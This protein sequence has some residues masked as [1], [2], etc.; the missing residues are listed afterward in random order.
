MDQSFSPKNLRRIWDLEARRGR[1]RLDLFPE[2]RRAYETARDAKRH[3]RAV[4]KSGVQFSGPSKHHP[5][6]LARET[7][8]AADELLELSL[9]RT[10]ENLIRSVETDT[11]TWGLT[12]GRVLHGKR[13]IYTIGATPEIFF[14]DK[15]IQRVLASTL[16]NRPL[17]RQ[18]VVAGLVR[19]IDNSLPKI[20]VRVDVKRFYDNID[21]GLLRSRLDRSSLSPS[22]HRLIDKLLAEMEAVTNRRRGIPAGV[23]MSAKLAELYIAQADRALRDSR[24]TLYFARYVDDIILVR[25]EEQPGSVKPD[26]VK[27]EIEA[28][29]RKLDLSLNP[30]KIVCSQLKNRSLDKIDFLGYEIKYQG[31]RGL[32][33][34]LT[35]ERQKTIQ[36]R[37][38]RAFNAWDRADDNNHGRRSLLLDRVRFLTGNTRLSHNKRNALVGVYFSNPHL[39]DMD[40]LKRL[41]RHLKR[42]ALQSSL[43]PG[44]DEKV[45][46]LSFV[47]GFQ[48]R[49]IHRWSMQRM[50]RLKG[51]WNV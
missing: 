43:P 9:T 33:V 28:E 48:K 11:F 13:Q 17:G 29:L 1:D 15:Q 34:G 6:V 16:P 38:D 42:R 35:K 3:A 26:A 49:T 21:H 2:V 40:S 39:T 27:E 23:G 12:P 7:R 51:A 25:G 20:V 4:R 46:R 14:A 41:D 50:K 45:A 24:G 18:S 31:R 37:L 30:K 32:I 10:S 44:L 22:C 8:Q 19:T 47:N 5:D 36:S